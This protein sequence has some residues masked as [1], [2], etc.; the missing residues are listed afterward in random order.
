MQVDNSKVHVRSQYQNVSATRWSQVCYVATKGVISLQRGG[1]QALLAVLTTRNGEWIPKPLVGR[2]GQ[3][4]NKGVLSP[5]TDFYLYS[6]FEGDYQRHLLRNT[7]GADSFDFRVAAH[8]PSAGSVR[9]MLPS[10]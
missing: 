10:G 9:M 4:E 5:P 2:A 1:R 7:S 6:V 3:T 8:P